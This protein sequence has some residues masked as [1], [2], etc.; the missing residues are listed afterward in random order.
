MGGVDLFR[1]D[2]AGAN[3]GIASYWWVNTIDPRYVHADQHVIVFHPQYN[4]KSSKILFITVGVYRNG[5][6]FLR[7]S[8]TSGAPDI[9]FDLG[10]AGDA[11][12]SGDWD[13]LP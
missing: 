8:N 12:I 13:G 4:G 11:P 7:N 6:F 10:V 1:S 3:R 9:S 5:T 2:D